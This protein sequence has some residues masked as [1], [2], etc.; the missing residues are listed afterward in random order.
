MLISRYL[1]I[2]CGSVSRHSTA[3]DVAMFLGL[4]YMYDVPEIPQTIF[5]SV[6]TNVLGLQDA[7]CRGPHCLPP[8][9]AQQPS[10]GRK[11]YKHVRAWKTTCKG[12]GREPFHY[13]FLSGQLVSVY[14]CGWQAFRIDPTELLGRPRAPGSCLVAFVGRR[15]AQGFFHAFDLRL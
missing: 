4:S 1:Y 8:T 2:S 9:S 3:Q 7:Q 13:T 15:L 10:I 14:G 12:K 6:H 5:S 11:P